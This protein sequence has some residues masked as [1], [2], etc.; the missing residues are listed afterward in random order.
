MMG[1]HDELS[2][3]IYHRVGPADPDPRSA[4]LTVPTELFERQMRWLRRL[5]FNAIR[6][7]DW[8]AYNQAGTPLPPRPVLITF[9]DAY[10][11]VATYALPIL[12][13]YHLASVI[14]VPT[15]MIGKNNEW[16]AGSSFP[17]RR[18]MTAEEI[19][20]WAARGVEFGGHSRHHVDLTKLGATELEAEVAGCQEDLTRLLGRPAH[21]F[22]YPFGA[23]NQTVRD[24]TRRAWQQGVGVTEGRNPRGVDA[25]DLKRTYVFPN[26]LMVDFVSRAKLGYSPLR[27]AQGAVRL[28][29]RLAGLLGRGE[30]R[31]GSP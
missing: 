13:R 14:Y 6:T 7:A 3:L 2:V 4:W 21:S 20:Q 31:A 17:Q 15:A 16:D 8:T 30:R 25:Y 26:D 11:D 28:R 19:R 24:A 9:D 12:E 22:A 23:Q 29:S 18:L 10:Q 1:L 5:G 27:R